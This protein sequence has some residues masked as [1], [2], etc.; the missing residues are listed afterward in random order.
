MNAWGGRFLQ[1]FFSASRTSMSRLLFSLFLKYCIRLQEPL[2]WKGGM[3]METYKGSGDMSSFCNNR[4][5]IIEDTAAK[6]FHSWLR[7]RIF[8]TIAAS[9][10]RLCIWGACH[11]VVLTLLHCKLLA[12]GHMLINL[13]CR[14]HRYVLTLW[15]LL[16]QSSDLG[17][18]SLQLLLR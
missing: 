15:E 17:F 8:A 2:A 10:Q 9:Y 12:F 11:T 13:D 5:V 7:G 18:W 4:S 3:L 6:A 1:S 14:R 16:T